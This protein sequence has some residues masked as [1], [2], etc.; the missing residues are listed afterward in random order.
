V[1]KKDL[2]IRIPASDSRGEV[3]TYFRKKHGAYSQIDFLLASPQMASH[4]GADRGVIV[5]MP[6]AIRAS[7]HRLVYTDLIFD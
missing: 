6:F 4:I 3:W 2:T 5:D 1:G 7:D